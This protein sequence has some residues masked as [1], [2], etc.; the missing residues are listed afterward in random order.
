MKCLAVLLLWLAPLAA[1]AAAVEP[2]DSRTVYRH[3]TVDVQ[4]DGRSVDTL[5]HAELMI[6]DKAA[7][8]YAQVTLSYKPTLVDFEVL[9]AYT[10]KKDGRRIPVP[11]ALIQV[12]QGRVASISAASFDD[13]VSVIVIFP[14]TAAGDTTVYKARW[15]GKKNLIPGH[16]WMWRSFQPTWLIGEYRLTLSAPADYRLNVKTLDMTK[17]RERR[18]A[19][20]RT[21]TWRYQNQN[22]APYERA[23]L[24]ATQHGAR[25]FVSSFEDYAAMARAQHQLWQDKTQV[26]EAIRVLAERLTRGKVAPEEK[27]RRIYD[28]VRENIKYVALSL[29]TGGWEP[30]RAQEILDRGSGDCK[31]HAV[32]LE[33]LLAAV[34]I[35]ST[36]AL[37]H[38]GELR[39]APEPPQA[40]FN[41]VISYVPVFDVYLDSTDI[42]APFGVLPAEDRARPVLHL[43]LGQGLHTTPPDDESSDLLVSRTRYVLHEDGSVEGEQTLSAAGSRQIELRRWFGSFNEYSKRNWVRD[44]LIAQGVLGEGTIDA[45]DIAGGE[46]FVV[47][48]RFRAQNYF[49]PAAVVAM[50]AS[51][52]HQFSPLLGSFGKYAADRR[53]TPYACGAYRELQE[54]TMEFPPQW[55]VELPAAREFAIADRSFRV[56]YEQDGASVKVRRDYVST[57]RGDVCDPARYASEKPFFE[58]VMRDLRSQIFFSAP[59]ATAAVAR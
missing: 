10:L 28:W 39:R 20:R 51:A 34:G 40:E 13:S 1:G 3:E 19:G 18:A 42:H 6:T 49:N 17:P 4:G 37:I 15:T 48:V 58:S 30:H 7:R 26:T 29:D 23:S 16:F 41:H 56:S 45:E 31:D 47:K 53:L 12:Q 59:P 44:R 11:D 8:E 32:L 46:D 54:I 27:A 2:P 9:E 33:A 5:E 35:D 43:K 25:I 22:K 52:W 21:W 57:V 14:D 38:T 24:H 55:R 50:E 36:P